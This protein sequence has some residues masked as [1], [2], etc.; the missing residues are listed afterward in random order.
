MRV[1]VVNHPRFWSGLLRFI[2]GVRP[3]PREI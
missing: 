2:F 1:I 3:Q